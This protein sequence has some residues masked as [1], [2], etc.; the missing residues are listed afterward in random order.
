MSSLNEPD[1]L[2]IDIIAQLQR[3]GRKPYTEIAADLGVSEGTVRNRVQRL[4]AD[5]II[6]VTGMADPLRMGYDAPALIGISVHPAQ[7]QSASKTIAN[8]PE[9]SYSV[10]VSGEFDIFVEVMCRDREDLAS[11][12]SDRLHQVPG[13]VRTQTFI[14]LK[15]FKMAFGAKSFP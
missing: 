11:F 3:D 12:I 6:Q 4:V 5:Q 8:F 9:V 7:L 13:I 1:Q 10:L 2:D 15:T 14:I